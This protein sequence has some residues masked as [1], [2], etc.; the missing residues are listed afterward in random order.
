MTYE[1]A[2]ARLD[3]FAEKIKDVP[4]T[5]TPETG[6]PAFTTYY[7]TREDRL[8]PPYNAPGSLRTVPLTNTL[9]QGPSG[10]LRSGQAVPG[11]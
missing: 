8:T 9:T 3:A 7:G 11:E 2:L 6:H 1:E 5:F 10:F 4:V